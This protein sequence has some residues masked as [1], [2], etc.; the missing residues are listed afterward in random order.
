MSGAP[1]RG[2]TP[3]RQRRHQRHHQHNNNHQRHHHHRRHQKGLQ[4]DQ[5][6][7]EHEEKRPKVNPIFL[8]ALQREQRIVEVR[9]EDYDK[10]NRIK[11]TKTAQGWR[12]IPRTVSNVMFESLS[13][14]RSEKENGAEVT[15]PGESSGSVQTGHPV[16][17]VRNSLQ[18]VQS[19]E[20]DETARSKTRED[21]AS[22]EVADS[23]ISRHCDFHAQDLKYGRKVVRYTRKTERYRRDLDTVRKDR[24]LQP[25]VVLEQLHLSQ[26]PESS[27][28]SVDR[29]SK[30]V[31]KDVEEIDE[32]ESPV[33]EE[34]EATNDE[35]AKHPEVDKEDLQDI[36]N[37]L[38]ATASPALATDTPSADLPSPNSTKT[39][40]EFESS[41]T[42][43]KVKDTEDPSVDLQG[44]VDQDEANNSNGIIS[45]DS[46]KDVNAENSDLLNKETSQDSRGSGE[47]NINEI[48]K[49]AGSVQEM[50]E[51]VRSK[52]GLETDPN[53]DVDKSLNCLLK[54]R[55]AMVMTPATSVA[56]NSE[57]ASS[58]GEESSKD[59]NDSTRILKA[60]RNT[61]GLSVSIATR[62]QNPEESRNS[63][64]STKSLNSSVLSSGRSSTGLKSSTSETNER[65]LEK[66]ERIHKPVSPGSVP[67]EV[68]DQP[69]ADDPCNIPARHLAGLSITIP[70]Y[71]Y[72]PQNNSSIT[73][74]AANRHTDSPESTVN[75]PKVDPTGENR[76][77]NFDEV[78]H[79]EEL[80]EEDDVVEEEEDDI[81]EEE[82]EDE[83]EYPEEDED[84]DSQ[85]LEDL[86][87][88][89][90]FAH[91]NGIPWRN[92]HPQDQEMEDKNFQS[93]KSRNSEAV[94]KSNK[95]QD[96][97]HFDEQVLEELRSQGT[98]V[99]P[100]PSGIPSS[101]ASRRPS[102][103]YLERLLPSPP[104]SVSCSEDAKNDLT[105]KGILA[106]PTQLVEATSRSHDYDRIKEREVSRNSQRMVNQMQRPRYEDAR[107]SGRPM[108]S[109]DVHTMLYGSTDRVSSK[110]PM[111]AEW[112][113][114]SRQKIRAGP[115]MTF[116]RSIPKRS[117]HFE[118]IQDPANELRELIKT[119][120]HLIP[121]PLLV[122]R[123]CLPALAAA[124]S[125]EIPKLL[126]SRPELRLPEALTR[127]EL[128]RDPDLLVISLVH[129]QH[130]LDHGEGPVSRSQLQYPAPQGKESI[131]A[132][133]G[134]VNN[135]E[136]THGKPKLT[137]KPIGTLMP[138]PIDLSSNRRGSPYPALLRVRSGLVKQ[139]PEVTSTASS[140]DDSQL[141]HP[142]FGSQKRQQQQ[143]HASWHRTTLA[144]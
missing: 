45:S 144:S 9:C 116:F 80:E 8:W 129:L 85:V 90:G 46:I 82:D 122:P 139:E 40:N 143:H 7:S 55:N 106:S 22:I 115:D 69:P 54:W 113:T 134:S 109:G 75:I 19:V 94:A 30:H 35:S 63:C 121:D 41:P 31:H 130:V 101:P 117:R 16:D 88:H 114:S 127:P 133:T 124:P 132:L 13:R 44:E 28:R 108:S 98:V 34:E 72:R 49:G 68:E 32:D 58:N 97:E 21:I 14:S 84:C 86:R 38:D 142:L 1:A 50:G 27:Q 89:N 118:K 33:R 56:S 128:L 78:S 140:P 37:M 107:G 39:C 136:R 3:R 15:Q 95:Y 123:D 141:W 119:S 64:P 51:V 126:A 29:L 59:Y 11:L 53:P 66:D 120:G 79:V 26:L 52:L 137:C 20:P 6:G 104:C 91:K 25:R 48:K 125:T 105:L 70:N 112:T 61:P 43:E 67:T 131:G 24:L 12:S 62:V 96:L 103:A 47:S 42:I 76:S 111:S 87:K 71:R 10:R 2:T 65:P 102:S 23:R 5:E 135:N 110:R 17:G 4:S 57:Y 18:S 74:T 36:L 138:A 73:I 100:Q 60:L 99:S 92:G 77:M 83:D 81:E 93:S